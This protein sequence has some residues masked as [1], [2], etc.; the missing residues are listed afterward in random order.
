M[1]A[2]DLLLERRLR[3]IA[4]LWDQS[5]REGFL[6][7]LYSATHDAK[8]E[9]KETELDVSRRVVRTLLKHRFIR[10]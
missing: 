6:E 2:F 7:I 10:F 8:S 1:H 9:A 3:D 4:L 5:I